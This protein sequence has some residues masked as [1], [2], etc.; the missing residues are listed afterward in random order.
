MLRKY[1]LSL[2][3]A[4]IV[5]SCG[6]SDGTAP[7]QEAVAEPSIPPNFVIII[8]DDLGFDDLSVHGNPH[9]STANLDRLAGESINFNNFYVSPV[10][11]TSRASLLTGKHYNAVGVS[12]V[13]GGRDYLNLEETIFPER[14]QDAGYAT[15][16]WGKWHNGKTEGYFPWQRGF[17]EAFQA[18]LYQHD[19]AYGL[20]NGELISTNK[21]AS[22]LIVDYATDFISRNQNK[23]FLAFVSFLA[24]HAEWMAPAIYRDKY[25]AQGLSENEASLY[26]MIEQMD[27]EIGRLLTHIDDLDLVDNTVI[28]FLSDNGPW[29]SNFSLITTDQWKARNPHKLKG[30]KAQLWENGIKSPLLIRKPDNPIQTHVNRPVI[31][32]DLAPAIL[33]LAG[34]TSPSSETT[35][36]SSAILDPDNYPSRNLL[37]ASHTL[38]SAAKNF[39]N[40]SPITGLARSSLSIDD[41]QL[42]VR[43]ERFKLIQNPRYAN[44]ET[45]PASKNGYVLIDVDN[46]PTESRNVYDLYPTEAQELLEFMNQA[47]R[48]I[49]DN[50]ESFKPPVFVIND[51]NWPYAVINGFGPTE[52]FGKTQTNARSLAFR[53]EGDAA[54]YSLDIR[55][56][57]NFIIYVDVVTQRNASATLQIETQQQ[58]ISAKIECCG[59]QRIGEIAF[60]PS[61]DDMLVTMLENHNENGIKLSIKRI[62]LVDSESD[63]APQDNFLLD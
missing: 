25:L 26:G 2:F 11:A 5:V 54:R 52:I 55:V 43:S 6:S 27:A 50:P 47:Y 57:R 28:V 24:P 19:N 35:T 36:T 30:A 56:S 34:L 62:F 63:A 59:F 22:E 8:A 10:C 13:H 40:Y 41:Q 51:A 32:S 17:D 39:N 58:D 4:V 21:W 14:L 15:G 60:A 20:L 45:R 16:M 61:K 29:H 23:P 18:K 33:S 7:P 53:Q 42:M 49:L 12:G 31:I 38:K 37:I 48:E 9:S 44:Y 46:D 1:I 3:V